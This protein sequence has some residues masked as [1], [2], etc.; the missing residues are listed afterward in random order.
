MV[1]VDLASGFLLPYPK[2]ITVK[3]GS[4]GAL[5]DLAPDAASRSDAVEWQVPVGEGTTLAVGRRCPPTLVVLPR[6]DRD[7]ETALTVLSDTEAFLSLALNAVNL[8]PHGAAGTAALGGLAARCTCVALTVSD[9]DAACALVQSLLE[10]LGSA[11]RSQI[12][13][14]ARPLAEVGGHVG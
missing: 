13:A 11:A 10:G 4:F 5:A 7:A 9:L 2:P 1:A 8:V 6:Y 3:S 14:L 12:G